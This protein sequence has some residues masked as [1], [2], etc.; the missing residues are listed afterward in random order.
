MKTRNYL[1]AALFVLGLIS[2]SFSS[3][4]GSANNDS[5][6]IQWEDEDSTDSNGGGSPIPP[7]GH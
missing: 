4:I 5:F 7:I 6:I 1:I 3:S 2:V